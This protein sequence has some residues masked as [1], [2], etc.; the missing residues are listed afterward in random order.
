MHSEFKVLLNTLAQV[1]Y[2]NVT[3]VTNND[4]SL[5][6]KVQYTAED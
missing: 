1:I 6:E 2:T 4:F 5:I 3:N